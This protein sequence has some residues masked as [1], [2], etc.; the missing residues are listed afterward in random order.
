PKVT[1]SLHP[2]WV[3]IGVPA[4]WHSQQSTCMTSPADSNRNE[5]WWTANRNIPTSGYLRI[6]AEEDVN[7]GGQ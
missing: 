5:R 4:G 7:G 6:Q 3:E 2:I 1:L